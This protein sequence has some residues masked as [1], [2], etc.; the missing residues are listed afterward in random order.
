LKNLLLGDFSIGTFL[1]VVG[2]TLSPKSSIGI[3]F[4]LLGDTLSPN[5]NIL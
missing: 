1:F 4:I 2:D 3:S 5:L